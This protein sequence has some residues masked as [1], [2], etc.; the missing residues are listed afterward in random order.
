M[1]RKFNSTHFT[2]SPTLTAALDARAAVYQ[3]ANIGAPPRQRAVYRPR[4]RL[5]VQGFPE[6]PRP[7]KI[8]HASQNLGNAVRSPGAAIIEIPPSQS[9]PV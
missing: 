3:I 8:R 6:A 9:R 4:Q 5:A 7:V 1:A 2:F